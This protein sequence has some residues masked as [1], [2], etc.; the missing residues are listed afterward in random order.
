MV[1]VI[2]RTLDIIEQLAGAPGDVGVSDLHASLGLPLGTVHR[3]L[4]ALVKR[5]YAVQDPR[6]R[7][8]A[9]GPKLIEVGMHAL[10][11]ARA[12]VQQIARPHLEAVTAQTGET[13]N[14]VVPHGRDGVY[15]D[16]VASPHLVRMFTE[17]G[18][19]AP[20]YCTAAGK[21]MLAAM[22]PA[23][24][25]EYL[26]SVPLEPWTPRT[27]TTPER[28]RDEL[29]AIRRRGWAVDD[30]ERE[31]GVRCVAAPIVDGAGRVVAAISVSGPTTRLTPAVAE[32]IGP[33]VRA[34]ADACSARLGGPQAVPRVAAPAA[35][36]SR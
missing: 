19:R 20:L 31:L 14:L 30:E 36:A 8:Y 9:P 32:Q 16:Q 6:T 34:A 27:I 1:Q 26:A 3:L 21:A 35:H 2:D 4:S 28:L 13:T 25:E 18:R 24:V 22:P 11:H 29:A 5:G 33:L 10:G 17:I 12:N 23:A 7:R 15:V